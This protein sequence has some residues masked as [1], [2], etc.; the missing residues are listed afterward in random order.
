[1]LVRSLIAHSLQEFD[2]VEEWNFESVG[3]EEKW[4]ALSESE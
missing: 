3:E 2:S 4:Y 1:M